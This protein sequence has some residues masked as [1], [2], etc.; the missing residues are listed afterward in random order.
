MESKTKMTVT[1]AAWRLGVGY[2]RVHGLILR[3]VLPAIRQ[4]H[5]DRQRFLIDVA[6]L[7]KAAAAL[8]VE[9]DQAGA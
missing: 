2:N 1:D 5:G 4:P 3:G 8:G 6:D 7:P 9:L